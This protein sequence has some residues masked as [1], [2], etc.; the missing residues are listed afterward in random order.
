M[1]DQEDGLVK[2]VGAPLRPHLQDRLL[3][4][5]GGDQQEERARI[6][7]KRRGEP[8]AAQRLQRRNVTARDALD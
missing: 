5:A 1:R 8:L 6:V 7:H 2:R 4:A 3:G